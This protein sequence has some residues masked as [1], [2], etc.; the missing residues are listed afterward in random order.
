MD[1]ITR[2]RA[3]Q[4]NVV[5]HWQGRDTWAG[6]IL[7]RPQG[8][9]NN[10]N[11]NNDPFATLGSRGDFPYPTLDPYLRDLLAECMACQWHRRPDLRSLIDR[12]LIGASMG[13]QA[14]SSIPGAAERETDESIR[15]VLQTL[16]Y[17]AEPD[18]DA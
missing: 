9:G 6:R 13:P 17:D 2:P 11:H 10:N 15:G 7:P 1:L 16:V 14:Y 5:T 4:N 8:G 3:G 18:A 12:V